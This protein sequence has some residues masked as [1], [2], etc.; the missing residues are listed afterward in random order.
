M[1]KISLI[2]LLKDG[3]FLLGQRI[4]D[5]GIR[6]LW[7]PYGGP[8]I[9]PFIFNQCHRALIHVSRQTGGSRSYSWDLYKPGQGIVVNEMSINLVADLLTIIDHKKYRYQILTA[10]VSAGYAVPTIQFREHNWFSKEE[11]LDP[12]FKMSEMNKYF[13]SLAINSLD[14]SCTAANISFDL[15][16]KLKRRNLFYPSPENKIYS[17]FN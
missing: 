17:F 10:E 9:L 16:Q 13:T 1:K 12:F 14:S 8:N 2:Y 6:G 7:S 11:I 4:E 15:A 3:K 5:F